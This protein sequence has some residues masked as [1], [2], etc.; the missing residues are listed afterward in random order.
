MADSNTRAFTE[1]HAAL[2]GSD[3]SMADSN[4]LYEKDVA[5]LKK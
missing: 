5:V 4:T 2:T 3:S 1:L